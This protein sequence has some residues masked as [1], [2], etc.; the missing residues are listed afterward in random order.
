MPAVALTDTNG[1]HAAVSF[2][3]KAKDQKIKPIVGVTL[4][5]E[6]S[7][8]S[9]RAQR[10]PPLSARLLRREISPILS[11]DSPL[12]THHLSSMVLL[13]MDMEGYS[14]LCQLTTL[15]Q[16]G[17]TKLAGLPARQA[18]ANH[19]RMR[20]FASPACAGRPRITN[21]ENGVDEASP[22]PADGRPLTL[23]EL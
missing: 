22:S 21:E 2:Y 4:D 14:N 13:A 23:Q 10:K 6:S 5:V 7:L 20:S 1:M 17:T 8:S 18:P 3:K 15:R 9:F 19:L 11:L 16:L 12:V